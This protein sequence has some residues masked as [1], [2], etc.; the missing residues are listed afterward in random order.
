MAV[1]DAHGSRAAPRFP[2][3]RSAPEARGGIRCRC[4]RPG[5]PRGVSPHAAPRVP[6]SPP[7]RV[8]TAGL[9]SESSLALMLHLLSHPLVRYPWNAFIF[10]Q[11]IFYL[12]SYTFFTF[13]Y[14]PPNNVTL[15]SVRIVSRVPS[16]FVT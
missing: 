9:V 11:S 3:P 5:I 10:L 12:K 13:C 8:H 14:F 15:V 6:A 16:D 1:R 2:P 7:G 4:A